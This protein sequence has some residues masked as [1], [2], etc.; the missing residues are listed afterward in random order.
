MLH[1]YALVRRPAELPETTGLGGSQLRAVAVDR[2]VDAIVSDTRGMTAATEPAILAHATVVDALAA[3]N[4][5]VLPARFGGGVADAADLGRRLEAQKE[6]LVAALER[7]RGCTEIG[8]RVLDATADDAQERPRSGREYMRRRSRDIGRAEQL[9]RELH[10][11]LAE[12]ARESTHRVLAKPDVLLTAAYL[13]RREQIESFT[14]AISA[15]ERERP[16]L[17]FVCTGPWPPYS[18]A[19]LDPDAP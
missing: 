1:L 19:L 7:V 16:G 14:A 2:Q 8:L 9:A 12:L 17:T 4:D 11:A 3:A 5:A 15:A 10:E 6:Q 13:V 18:F